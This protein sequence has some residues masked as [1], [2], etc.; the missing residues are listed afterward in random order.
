[1][2]ARFWWSWWLCPEP[3]TSI[4]VGAGPPLSC[5]GVCPYRI[6]VAGDFDGDGYA[7]TAVWRPAE[8]NWYI[9]PSGNPNA[10][11]VR[12]WGLPGD[13]PVAHDYDGDGKTD[14]AVWRPSTGT[15]YILLSGSGERLPRSK[16]G[17]PSHVPLGGAVNRAF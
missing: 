12:Q 7:D 5:N 13:I 15:W 9:R 8:G 10:P 17:L 11:F 16:W 6:P 4:T 2:E 3:G 1:M 14:L